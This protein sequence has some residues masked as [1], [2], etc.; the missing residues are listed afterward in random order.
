MRQ[1]FLIMGYHDEG[2]VVTQTVGLDNVFNQLAVRVVKTVKGLIEDEQFGVLDKSSGE[3]H[4]PLLT[5]REAHERTVAKMSNAKDVHPPTANLVFFFRRAYIKSNGVFKATG[6]NA[7]G[8]QILVV[9]PVHFWG[10]VP[11]VALDVP[12]GFTSATGLVEKGDVACV[13]LRIVGT[14]K[15]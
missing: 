7:D 10:D 1:L 3:Q 13:S 4:Q 11:D 14:N 9:G 12:N 6:H 8:G 15:A 5:T 2:L